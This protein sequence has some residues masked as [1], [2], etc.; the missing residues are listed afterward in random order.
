MGG[1]RT[2]Q[3]RGHDRRAAPTAHSH[4]QRL[5]VTHSRWPRPF[6]QRI[7]S[8]IGGRITLV[9]T[10]TT[11]AGVGLTAPM[12]F[13]P[14][15][16]RRSHFTA[17]VAP[18]LVTPARG[19]EQGCERRGGCEKCPTRESPGPY[20]PSHSQRLTAAHTDS[21]RLTAAWH[22]LPA[23][24]VGQRTTPA[25]REP[26]P[27]AA[28]SSLGVMPGASPMSTAE[29]CAPVGEPSVPAA[30]PVKRAIRCQRGRSIDRL[31]VRALATASERA[32]TSAWALC[33]FVRTRVHERSHDVGKCR[34]VS[35]A[36]PWPQGG[37]SVS[38]VPGPVSVT[39]HM[40]PMLIVD[41]LSGGSLI[42]PGTTL[43]R[44]SPAWSD[45][46]AGWRRSVPW[47]RWPTGMTSP[48]RVGGCVNR[49]PALSAL[50][51]D[52]H[53][54]GQLVIDLHECL[55]G[56]ATSPC[57]TLAPRRS[58]RRTGC[59]SIRQP[60]RRPPCHRLLPLSGWLAPRRRRIGVGIGTG[61]V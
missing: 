52:G 46:G 56:R 23:R 3:R 35:C 42:R 24:P 2:A 36:R 60:P 16:A 54:R 49:S 21:Q 53:V 55:A 47:R 4:S 25:W 15:K 12:N 29:V 10:R 22:P 28:S 41:N 50:V 18:P 30:S 59:R 9:G 6:G 7:S 58:P 1:T 38:S 13:V 31:S 19:A 37:H 8:V 17:E 48:R 5:T 40:S 20:T 39:S 43:P 34:W 27:N 14:S 51:G 45:T 11:L 57:D 26:R 33:H 44:V 61:P 32:G